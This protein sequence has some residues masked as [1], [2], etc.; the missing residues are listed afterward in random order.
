MANT[1]SP[2]NM[3]TSNKTIELY[4]FSVDI[5]QK[6]KNNNKIKIN[7]AGLTGSK[8][9]LNLTEKKNKKK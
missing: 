8:K 4:N 6:K 5:L 1:L 9:K 7:D 2:K 3:K